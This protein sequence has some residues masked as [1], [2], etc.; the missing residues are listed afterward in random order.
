MPGRNL[1]A[2][3]VQSLS[4]AGGIW[5]GAFLRLTSP[6]LKLS[7]LVTRESPPA[8]WQLRDRKTNERLLLD[9]N[10]M[11]SESVQAVGQ[12]QVAKI[13]EMKLPSHEARSCGPH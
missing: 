3:K 6:V 9:A 10:A 2:V 1:I 12:L 4:G 7:P 13:H 11:A 8:H 5:R